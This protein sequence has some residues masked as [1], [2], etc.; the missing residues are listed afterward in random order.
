[1]QIRVLFI[2]FLALLQLA[3]QLR[4][5]LGFE[6]TILDEAHLLQLCY[7]ALESVCLAHGVQLTLTALA[8]HSW[9]AFTL[10]RILLV[11]VSVY[12]GRW[13]Q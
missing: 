8:A 5:L 7:S 10:L 3:Q 9:L 1:M 12:V 13:L 4:V 2:D 11:P 6:A